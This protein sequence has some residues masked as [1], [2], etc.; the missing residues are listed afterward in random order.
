MFSCILHNFVCMKNK[1]NFLAL[2]SQ[3]YAK[4]AHMG[5]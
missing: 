1:G 4:D 3:W 5:L 2:N